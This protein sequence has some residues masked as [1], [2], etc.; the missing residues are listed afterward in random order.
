MCTPSTWWWYKDITVGAP[1]VG[2]MIGIKRNFNA[3]SGAAAIVLVIAVIVSLTLFCCTCGAICNT[4][5][6]NVNGV[7][8]E[9]YNKK[10]NVMHLKAH[11]KY[12]ERHQVGPMELD[13]ELA[14]D[15]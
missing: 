14:R 9:G 15:A 6:E 4:K 7:S 1:Q 8:G 10:F 13:E 11:N 3:T 2:C 12:R 5:G